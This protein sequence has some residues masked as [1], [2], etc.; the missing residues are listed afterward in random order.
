MHNTCVL[1]SEK[2]NAF[3]NGSTKDL[4]LR[5]AILNNALCSALKSYCVVLDFL[6]LGKSYLTG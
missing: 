3:Y 4:K 5:F 6:L 2:D 1:Q